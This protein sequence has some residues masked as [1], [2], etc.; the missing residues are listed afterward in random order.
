[1]LVNLDKD[2]GACGET[3]RDDVVFP[4]AQLVVV[5]PLKVQQRLRPS[6]PVAGHNEKVFM[7]PLVALH[8]VVRSQVL[9][10]TQQT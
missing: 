7:I 8:G 4:E 2:V 3:H 10:Q 5:V 1:M 9:H 6:P